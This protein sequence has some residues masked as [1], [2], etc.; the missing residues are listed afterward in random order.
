MTALEGSCRT[1]IG[2]YAH[3]AE[4]RLHLST[5]MLSPDGSGRWTRS[6]DVA[7][8]AALTQADL[9]AARVLGLDL[10]GQV[11]AVAGDQK[12]AL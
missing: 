10:G 5:E 1:A 3:I 8:P 12:I 2:A 7:A 11:Q 9:S 6:G 4:G